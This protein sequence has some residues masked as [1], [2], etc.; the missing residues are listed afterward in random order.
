MMLKK[1]VFPVLIVAS[2]ACAQDTFRTGVKEVVAPVVVLDKQGQYVSDLQ[3]HDFQLT[4]NGKPQNINV[5]VNYVPISLVVAIQANAGVEPVLPT[6]RR[7]G[8]LL[9]GLITG[10]QGEVA[11]VAFDHRIQTLQGFT[12]DGAKLEAA[13][14]KLRPGSSTSRLNDAV[15]E[16]VRM[17]RTRPGDRRRVLLLIS[18]SRDYGSESK[19]R[20]ALT[21]LQFA[22]VSVYSVSMNYFT[23]TARLKEQ[24][25]RPDPI[26]AAARPLPAGVPPLP[27]NA[28]QLYGNPMNSGDFLPVFE[29]IFRAS[30]SIFVKNPLQV[31]TK[32]TGG[33]ERAFVSQR[34]LEHAFSSIGSELHSQYVISYAPSNKDEGGF[35]EIA[36]SVDRA[37]LKVRTRPGY[38]IASQN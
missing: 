31:Y 38:W 15:V 2:L 24:D 5:N 29:E 11:I 36:V 3:S 12:T 7:I 21:D 13:L 28:R 8:P 35:H 34:D 37:G 19:V 32:Y 23:T 1:S 16:S 22:N 10:E 9:Q 18:E 27:D 20:E 6:V 30:K 33:D 26:P 14:A 25:P 17:L 4:D